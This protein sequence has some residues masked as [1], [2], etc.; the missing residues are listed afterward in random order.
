MTRIEF[1][2]FLSLLMCSDPW[3]T[4]DEDRK[5]VMAW[6]DKRAQKFGFTDWIDAYLEWAR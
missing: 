6:A 5:I 2:A 1:G 3:P 4:G